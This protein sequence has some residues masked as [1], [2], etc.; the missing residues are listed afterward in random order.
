MF[1]ALFH[2]EFT[3]AYGVSPDGELVVPKPFTEQSTLQPLIRNVSILS[4]RF[5]YIL[6]FVSGLLTFLV[7]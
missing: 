2:L 4:V 5:P 3:F 6:R 1:R 7:I